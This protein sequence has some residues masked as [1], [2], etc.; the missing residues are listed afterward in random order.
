M[1]KHSERAEE[2]Y[3]LIDLRNAPAIPHELV[4]QDAPYVPAGAT[5]ESATFTCS[6]C[7]AVVIINPARTRPSDRCF[8]CNHRVCP[9]CHSAL[10][11]STCIPM[12]KVLD[13]LQTA[14]ERLLL[15]NKGF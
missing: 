5:Y 11:V 15:Q 3:L 1:S 10:L 9:G 7:H 4:P 14:A 13:N 2:G 6:H 12:A 8:S